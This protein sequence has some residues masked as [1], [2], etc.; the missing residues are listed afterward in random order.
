MIC[1]KEMLWGNYSLSLETGKIANQADGSVVARYGDTVVLCT[2]VSERKALEEASFFPLTVN[3]IEKFYAAGKIP[4]GFIKR[5]GRPSERETL[6]SR[7]IDRS[8]RPLFPD[9]FKNEIQIVCTLLSNDLC[10]DPSIPALIGASA[11]LCISGVPFNGPVA[12]AHVGYS[13]K[14]FV[15]NSNEKTDLDLIVAGTQSGIL[16]VESEAQQL[17]ESIMLDSL[18]YAHLNYQPVIQLINDLAECAGKPRWAVPAIEQP[19]ELITYLSSPEFIEAITQAYSN[20]L[21]LERYAEIQS[22]LD[23]VFDKF[24]D[25]EFSKSLITSMFHDACSK[26]VRNNIMDNNMRIDGRKNVDIRPI[27]TEV[28]VLPKVHGSAIFNRGETQALVVATLGTAQDEQIIDAL[29][30]EYKER[31]LLHYNFP[32]FS[33]GE[34][35]KLGSPGRREIGH[36]KLAWRAL[37]PV[38]PSR[39]DFGYSIRVVSEITSCNGSSS[40]ATVCGTSLSLMDAGVPLKNAVA[41]IAMGMILDDNGK[42]VILSDI[43][44]DEDH[45]GD[46]DFKV[47]GTEHGITALQMDIKVSSVSFAVIKDALGQA[48]EGRMEI[49]KKMSEGIS[50]HRSEV[51]ENAPKMV[52]ITI[53]KDKIRDVIGSGGKVIREII[54]KTSA[55]IDI[56]D[57]GIISIAAPNQSNI[58]EAVTIIKSIAYEPEVGQIYSGIVVKVLDFGAFVRFHGVREGLVHISELANRR[59]EKVQD[60]VSEG[61]KVK[62]KFLGLDRGKYRLSIKA[63]T[64]S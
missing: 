59:V 61:D 56:N 43:M 27:S 63:V 34:V 62:V 55:K 47:A 57:D 26:F 31:F 4:G 14:E 13:N 36:G 20:K 2:V 18:E 38:L 12:C 32:P 51:N 23:N 48:K 54:E 7:L 21:K 22:V 28:A 42:Y 17:S 60:I 25:S 29:N 19:G 24:A 49:L 40:M 35:G 9:N 10:C 45:L 52:N 8:I 50:G 5:E 15:L 44:G 41:G 1:K 64:A 11:A 33:V 16:M 6:I 53:P 37:N 46:M 39:E 58:D 3:Y 30:G